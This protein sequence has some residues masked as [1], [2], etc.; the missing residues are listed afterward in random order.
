MIVKKHISPQGIILAVCDSD[1][2]GKKFETE[3]L[4]LDLTSPF[5]AG[6]EVTPEQLRTML[7]EAYIANVVGKESI[8][9]FKAEGLI[10]EGHLIEINGV[11]HAQIILVH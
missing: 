7:G 3:K 6:E 5:Y 4:Q 8:A 1:L 11:P 9:F 10:E 2:L